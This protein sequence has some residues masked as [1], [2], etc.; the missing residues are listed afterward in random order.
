[1]DREADLIWTS[2]ASKTLQA[3]EYATTTPNLQ[4]KSKATLM[5]SG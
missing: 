4:A 3:G 2:V 5:K 1:M